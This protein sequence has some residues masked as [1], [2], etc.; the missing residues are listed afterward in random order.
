MTA[1]AELALEGLPP[2]LFT[3][4][5]TRLTTWLDCPRRSAFPPARPWD[6]LGDTPDPG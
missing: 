2:R 3:C 4:T 5:P 6:A 1:Q